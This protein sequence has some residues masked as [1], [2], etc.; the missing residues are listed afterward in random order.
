MSLVSL[1]VS[2]L[3]GDA[4]TVSKEKKWWQELAKAARVPP[5]PTFLEGWLWL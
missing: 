2:R 1:C 3:K 5:F 4:V